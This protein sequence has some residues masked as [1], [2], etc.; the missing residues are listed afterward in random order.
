MAQLRSIFAGKKQQPIMNDIE[1]DEDGIMLYDATDDQDDINVAGLKDNREIFT[2]E[3][4]EAFV[5]EADAKNARLKRNERIVSVG[6]I[7]SI[8]TFIAALCWIYF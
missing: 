2:D 4:M 1:R 7:I 8:V 6:V 5:R 3:Y